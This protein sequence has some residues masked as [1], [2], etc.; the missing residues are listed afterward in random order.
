MGRIT[1]FSCG[2]DKGG[3]DAGE[4]FVKQN[5]Q[6]SLKIRMDQ[7]SAGTEENPARDTITCG[8]YCKGC[9]LSLEKKAYVCCVGEG[10]SDGGQASGAA[11]AST[12][13]Q[14]SSMMALASLCMVR[15]FV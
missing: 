8:G 6:G 15:L 7:S 1:Q 5:S 14:S 4:A 13:V 10:C 2:D 9:G 3:D 11:S 12:R